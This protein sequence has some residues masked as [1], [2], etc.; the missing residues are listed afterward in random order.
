MCSTPLDTPY[1]VWQGIQRFAPDDLSW[2]VSDLNN[3]AGGFHET[4]L[5]EVWIR[6]LFIL[7]E[8]LIWDPAIMH[9]WAPLSLWRWFFD[10][11]LMIKDLWGHH[12]G[13]HSFHGLSEPYCGCEDEFLSI[14]SH[15][16]TPRPIQ[17]VPHHP[18]SLHSTFHRSVLCSGRALLASRNSSA[19]PDNPWGLVGLYGS[20]L[21]KLTNCL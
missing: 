7:Y 21:L 5:G 9:C 1:L 10:G 4:L 13:S 14:T 18:L 17:R 3:R 16:P 8:S 20:G 6:C 12:L 15:C 19:L 2:W 11:L